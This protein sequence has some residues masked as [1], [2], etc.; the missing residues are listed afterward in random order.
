MRHA[1]KY[2]WILFFLISCGTSNR[3]SKPNHSETEIKTLE[4]SQK[5]EA[6]YSESG[7]NSTTR[8]QIRL[9]VNYLFRKTN[10][11]SVLWL[12]FQ[13]K[14][15]LNSADLDSVLVLDLDHENVELIASERTRKNSD[16]PTVSGR[17]TGL[18]S[19][20]QAFQ[21]PENLWISIAG[22]GEISYQLHRGKAS[23]DV[24]LNASETSK[25]KYFFQKA[26]AERNYGLLPVPE[27]QKK[28]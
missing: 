9:T 13:L 26:I 28:W 16:T 11:Q 5:P 10:R 17:K 27:G 1:K 18:S 19:N 3:I 25:L 24:G 2:F 22:S 12:E 7:S 15:P 4:M 20:S 14:T 8:K 23:I 6:Y 21:V